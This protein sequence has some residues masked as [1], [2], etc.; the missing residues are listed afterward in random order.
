MK[1]L[2]L[3]GSPRLGGNTSI[4]VDEMV[5]TFQ[6]EGIETEVVQGRRLR[7]LRASRP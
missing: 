4:A 6:E 3:N 2:I 7:T 1:V 5:R